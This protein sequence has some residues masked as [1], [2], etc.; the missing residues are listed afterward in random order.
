MIFFLKN[1]ISYKNRTVLLDDLPRNLATLTEIQHKCQLNLTWNNLDTVIGKP[2]GHSM[3]VLYSL[4]KIVQKLLLKRKLFSEAFY[5][6]IVVEG[7]GGWCHE[8]NGL[9]CWA[10]QH[11]GFKATMLCAK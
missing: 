10:L 2:L 9:L 1:K 7:R 6:K 3:L 5:Q 11:L 4:K 8:L